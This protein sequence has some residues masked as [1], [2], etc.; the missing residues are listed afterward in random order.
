MIDPKVKIVHEQFDKIPYPNAA[1]DLSF[2]D[3][4]NSL[5]KYCITTPHYRRF[6]KV[7]NS[8]KK[9]ILDVACGTGFLTQALVQ[10]NPGAK[11]IGIDI[12]EESIKWAKRRLE[13]HGYKDV[14][15]YV[16]PLEDI[17][18]LGLL[19]DFIHCNDTLYLLP[20]PVD[21]LKVMR[22]VLAP[23]GIIQGNLHSIYQRHYFYQGHQLY[24]FLGLMDD[25]PS[26]IEFSLL[27]EIMNSLDDRVMLKELTWKAS[28]DDT[29]LSVNY[30]LQEDKGY[31]ILQMFEIIR[32]S[33]LEFISMTNWNQWNVRDLYKDR[34]NPSEYLD[35]VLSTSSIEEKLQIYELLHP[36]NRL[37]DFWCGHIGEGDV[38]NPPE[39]WTDENW[40]NVMVYLHPKLKHSKI[41][42]S[43]DLAISLYAPFNI[44]VF[45]N[46][47][48][49]QP[50]SLYTTSC[51]CMHLL[52][53]KS[54][55]VKELT[56]EWLRIKPV[57]WLTKES[58]TERQAFSEIKQTLI[59]MESLMIVLLEIS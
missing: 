31:T 47:N 37:L 9:L 21:G 56:Q 43:L 19:F 51:A 6:Q 1:I 53:D 41:R 54:L 15:F 10:A 26:D 48:S 39:E 8:E 12:S 42:E 44:H 40:Q 27:R 34:N 46:I 30:L 52:W 36:V 32:D 50:I 14:E 58:I 25:S 22:T 49:S 17:P 3:D 13:Y 28:S 59:E 33:E 2:Q 57:N 35:M 38:V 18:K 20:N 5:F 29:T 4:I 11:V 7:V 16:M 45:L 23:Q 24:R 55:T